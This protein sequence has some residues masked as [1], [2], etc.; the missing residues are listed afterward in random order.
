MERNVLIDGDNLLHRAQAVY[1][2]N[3]LPEEQFVS[4]SGYPTGVIFGVLDMLSDWIPSIS[5][6]SRFIFFLDGKPTRR[7]SI[8]PT[9]KQEDGN[10]ASGRSWKIHNDIVLSD[11]FIAHNPLEVLVHILKLFGM[12][13]CQHNEEEAD[14]L[15][16]SFVR[17][18]TED[19][20]VIISSDK[21]LYQLL[22]IDEKIVLYRP[23]VSGNRFFD[24]ERAI[25]HMMKLYNVCVPP[26]NVRMF[27]A[28]T[29]D[30]SDGIVGISRLRKK[31]AA[32]LCHH[33][34]VEALYSTGLP[35]F[36]K[37]EKKNAI[38]SMNRIKINFD[39]IGLIDTINTDACTISNIVN[40]LLAQQILRDDLSI[41]TI[42]SHVFQTVKPGSIRTS[43]AGFDLIPEFLRDL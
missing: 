28:L 35:G 16:A 37:I 31:V 34:N 9:Y 40:H 15:I 29:G 17:A 27:K 22:S 41:R 26:A 33:Q 36:S 10:K 25:E 39:L 4:A 6:P 30:P 1:L 2:T 43:D 8:D 42:M 12:D 23:G 32:P 11:G 19:V 5:N 24:S 21:D 13:I 14:D 3:R 7:L 18:H 20:N 38:E